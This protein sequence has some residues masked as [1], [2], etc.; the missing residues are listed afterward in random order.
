V[1]VE[2]ASS[3]CSE[4]KAVYHDSEQKAVYQE[5]C[6]GAPRCRLHR[7]EQ[8]WR[9]GA[10]ANKH[11]YFATLTIERSRETIVKLKITRISTIE[12][13]SGSCFCDRR[14]F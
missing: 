9:V 6:S 10:I 11:I 13:L 8:S 14:H 12:I 4:Q 7:S 5:K 2:A 3:V 1:S